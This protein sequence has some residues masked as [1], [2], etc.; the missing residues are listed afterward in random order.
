MTIEQPCSLSP[1]REPIPG[2]VAHHEVLTITTH[3]AL[4]LVDLTD[5]ALAFCSQARIGSGQLIVQS[6]HTTA[7]ILVQENEPLLLDDL[8]RFLSRL[9]P[10]DEHYC[11]NDIGARTNVPPDE[12]PNGHSHAR[13]ALLPTSIQLVVIDGR[14]DL[15]RWQRIFLVELD[16][17]RSRQVSIQALGCP[18]SEPNSIHLVADHEEPAS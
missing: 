8:R 2:L 10:K 18:R 15:G 6:R 5:Q 16:G 13:A 17:P 1:A 4:E 7:S 9:A 3:Q 11:H 12:R 14:P